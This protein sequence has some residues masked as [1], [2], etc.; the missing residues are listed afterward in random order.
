M[1]YILNA[2]KKL[3]DLYFHTNLSDKEMG[4]S[5][6]LLNS[7]PKVTEAKD[8]S[9]CDFKSL[10]Y[11]DDLKLPN[12]LLDI[13]SSLC[14]KIG[15]C[16]CAQSCLNLWDLSVAHQASLSMEFSR[17]EY[18]SGLP[19]FYSMGSAWP[20]DQF[21]ISCISC[22]GRQIIYHCVTWEALE[23]QYLSLDNK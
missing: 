13:W 2:E 9:T 12:P 3:C 6:K 23:D 11:C 16:L 19:F 14:L 8:L 5:P 15:A 4:P 18:W 20:R 22:I 17:P 1:L 7:L 21:Q 10:S